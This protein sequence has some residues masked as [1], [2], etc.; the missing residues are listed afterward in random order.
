MT[1]ITHTCEHCRFWLM[2]NRH[3]HE[4]GLGLGVCGWVTD[5]HFATAAAQGAGRAILPAYRHRLAFVRSEAGGRL[6]TMA[7]FG[8]V[9]WEAQILTS[10]P[11]SLPG[12]AYSTDA[13]TSP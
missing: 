6:V 7:D 11:P 13:P 9:G 4:V 8:C 1:E 10:A 12:S 2:G 3:R 5:F